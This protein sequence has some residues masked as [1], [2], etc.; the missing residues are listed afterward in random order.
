MASKVLP[1][2]FVLILSGCSTH[3]DLNQYELMELNEPEERFQSEFIERSINGTLTFDHSN[4]LANLIAWQ[5]YHSCH[6]VY[7][8]SIRPGSTIVATTNSDVFNERQIFRLINGDISAEEYADQNSLHLAKAIVK[9]ECRRHRNPN[10]RSSI[11][12]LIS[13]VMDLLYSELK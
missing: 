10:E 13:P 6:H 12:Y 4:R 2:L 5:R 11:V 1:V 3:Y 7:G 8:Q 9:L